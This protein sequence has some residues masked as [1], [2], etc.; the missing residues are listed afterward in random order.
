MESSPFTPFDHMT[1]TKELQML[2]TV[3]PYMKGAQKKQFAL[4]IKYMELQN[5]AHLFSQEDK[6]LSMCSVGED[7]NST[8]A[9]LND[10]RQFCSAKEQETLDMMVNMLSMME[11]CDAMLVPHTL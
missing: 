5:T 9:L 8:V 1:Q 7:G 2:K 3:V 10:L 11:S 4:L 6:V